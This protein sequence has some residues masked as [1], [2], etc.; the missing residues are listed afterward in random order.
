VRSILHRERASSL[1]SRVRD[2]ARNH[3][4]ANGRWMDDD[5]H[6]SRR[7]RPRS[8]DDRRP[9]ISRARGAFVSRDVAVV[10]CRPPSAARARE[11]V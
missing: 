1:D 7:R 6:A 9:R 10:V 8:T 5:A 4:A 11:R 2:G 3:P